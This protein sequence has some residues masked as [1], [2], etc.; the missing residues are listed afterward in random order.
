MSLIAAP[1]VAFCASRSLASY[2]YF[3]RPP[4]TW[5]QPVQAVN[6]PL[7]DALPVAISGDLSVLTG[8]EL[9]Q[10]SSGVWAFKQNLRRPEFGFGE[11]AVEIRGNLIAQS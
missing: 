7:F 10:R 6:Y 2:F 9:F 3:Y 5:S 1:T 4:S 8:S 11:G